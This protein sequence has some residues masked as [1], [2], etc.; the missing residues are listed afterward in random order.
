MNSELFFNPQ[1]VIL[2]PLEEHDVESVRVS[3]LKPVGFRQPSD[4][5]DKITHGVKGLTVSRSFA[6]TYWRLPPRNIRVLLLR[7]GKNNDVLQLDLV[8]APL[9]NLPDYEALSYEWGDSPAVNPIILRDFTTLVTE[10]YTNARSRLQFLL[11]RIVGTRTLIG[12]NLFDALRAIR[13]T[14]RHVKIWVDALCINQRDLSEKTEQISKYMSEIYNRALN[15]RIWLG[16]ASERS[17]IAMDFVKELV[18][19]EELKGIFHRE[20]SLQKWA[21]L[22]ELMRSRWF[23][24][25]WVIQELSLARSASVYCGTKAVHWDDFADAISVFMEKLPMVRSEFQSAEKIKIKAEGLNAVEA[26]GARA[27]VKTTS[28]GNLLQ[29]GNDGSIMERK[30]TMEELVSS[31]ISF[32]S[33]DARDTV[34][35]L[36]AI[37]RNQERNRKALQPDYNK[38]LLEV[39][40]EFVRLCIDTSASL[41]IIC[42]HW[43]PVNT[44]LIIKQPKGE[45]LRF[46]TTLPS[47]IQNL[48]ASAFGTPD[49]IFRG[50]KNADSL[51]GLQ[52]IYNASGKHTA[53]TAEFAQRTQQRSSNPPLPEGVELT[54]TYDGTLTVQGL[55]LGSITALSP[56]M[57]PGILP[58]EVIAMGGWD[59]SLQD[60]ELTVDSIPDK[61]WRTLVANKDPEG[62]PPEGVY[63]RSCVFILQRED[64][65]GDVRMT[66]LMN[67]PE[68]PEQVVS[69]LKRVQDVTWNRKVFIGGEYG[70]LFGLVPKKAKEGDL[71]C[72]LY[73]CSVPVVLRPV[74]EKPL[75]GQ[76]VD[77]QSAENYLAS[78]R[79]VGRRRASTTSKS[80]K[81]DTAASTTAD[82]DDF[83]IPFSQPR[84]SGPSTETS[85]P[86]NPWTEQ[87]WAAQA[88]ILSPILETEQL[89]PVDLPASS[90]NGYQ[91]N[92]GQPNGSQRDPNTNSPPTSAVDYSDLGSASQP[93]Q[94]EPNAPTYYELIGECY[95]NGKM[96]G[97]VCDIEAYTKTLQ[98]FVL[99]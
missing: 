47:W 42:R 15:V 62:Q 70:E 46:D 84:E 79:T 16:G 55:V 5:L 14:D 86:A 87:P 50:R 24:R 75:L 81:V 44:T 94:P 45:N 54:E 8:R 29:K 18:Q 85:S 58:N 82:R 34:Y 65:N 95:V 26:F 64:V 39:Y 21:A 43:A 56:R 27:L 12:K 77:P 63:R 37:A 11:F 61:L 83:F 99:V 98:R 25:R 93:S 19:F 57:I 51:V 48:N 3:R 28:P 7:R 36:L 89:I 31:L 53:E 23:S 88:D 73:G 59:Y 6:H 90:T 71:I 97:E 91:S 68:C 92:G 30:K 40:T 69:F 22:I 76:R 9:D 1:D 17:D 67:D 66:E 60:K 2:E 33:Q 32:E 74:K 52:R 20:E 41:D 10:R 96:D 49:K 38:S 72:V 78:Y 35:A 80:V 4:L 13:K